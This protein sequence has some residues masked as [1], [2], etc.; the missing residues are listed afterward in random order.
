MITESPV[1]LILYNR[2][3]HTR[4]LFNAVKNSS[5]RRLYISIDGPKHGDTFDQKLIA[6][7]KSIVAFIDWKCE[8]K[9]LYRSENL[10]CKYGVAS[11][12]SWF[13]ENEKEGMILEDDCIP[14]PGFF[15]YCDW[16]LKTYREWK[17]VMHINGNNFLADSSLYKH[18]VGFVPLAQAWGWASWADRWSQF[19]LNPFYL[20]AGL[21]PANWQLSLTGRLSKLA[22]LQ[23]LKRG[24][25]TWDY[26]WQITI[27]NKRGMVLSYKENLVCNIGFG[28]NATHTHKK[29]ARMELPVGIF[30]APTT[31]T[32]LELNKILT[33]HYERKMSLH[34]FRKIILYIS[35][36][37][38]SFFKH[39]LRIVICKVLFFDCTPI[40]VSSVG[41][42]GSE[43]LS[44]SI[45]RSLVKSR[46]FYLPCFIQNH[47]SKLALIF[48]AKIDNN[49]GR[50]GCPI[51]KSHDLYSEKIT[52]SYKFIFT[53]DD[54]LATVIS[55]ANQGKKHGSIWIEKHTFHLQ[56]RGHPYELFE[57]DIF[58]Y[59]QQMISWKKAPGLSIHYSAIWDNKNKISSYLGFPLYLPKKLPRQSQS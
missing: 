4:K 48:C 59:E 3:Q 40:I 55:A 41:R 57:K 37:A 25:N 22:D 15:Q 33:S 32:S 19:E 38:V 52:A 49:M 7:V 1:L 28:E 10:G 31:D 42:A 47:I 14:A 17:G 20:E 58:N 16:A 36:S 53:F 11:A 21:V 2:P 35:R 9:R 18:D 45:A 43:M 46:F 34:S 26:Q 12:I 44:K 27:L 23:D 39:Q 24:V 56:G 8:V 30:S 51:I 54:R 29:D 6:E 5:P 50:H 13:F